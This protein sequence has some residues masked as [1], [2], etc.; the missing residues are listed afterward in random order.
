VSGSEYTTNSNYLYAYRYL[1]HDQSRLDLADPCG[2]PL[3][4]EVMHKYALERGSLDER[5]A[6]ADPD[7]Y[8]SEGLSGYRSGRGHRRVERS[9][10]PEAH[11]A[12]RTGAEDLGPSRLAAAR[13]RFQQVSDAAPERT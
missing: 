1:F 11:G 13:L 12:D 8:R 10:R 6:H 2:R 9:G 4:F 5:D 7:R 3:R